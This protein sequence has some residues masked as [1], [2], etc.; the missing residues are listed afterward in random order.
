MEKQE[1]T[2]KRAKKKKELGKRKNGN[3]YKKTGRL[4]DEEWRKEEIQKQKIRQK[5]KY[6]DRR[7]RR[8]EEWKNGI[9]GKLFKFDI[10]TREIKI[11]KHED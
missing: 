1:N 5:K 10:E 6:R 3:I 8:T 7:I 11:K 2:P 4:G 9:E